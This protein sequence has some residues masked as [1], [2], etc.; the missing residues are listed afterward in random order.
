MIE[1]ILLAL[2]VGT[3]FFF[4]IREERAK[5]DRERH[6]WWL[7]DLRD[8][9]HSIE[10]EFSRSCLDITQDSSYDINISNLKKEYIEEVFNKVTSR[11]GEYFLKTLPDYILNEY[12]RNISEIADIYLNIYYKERT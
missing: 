11:K 12:E 2:W 10:K 9:L 4:I 3:A 7:S 6:E 8:C 1:A 5:D